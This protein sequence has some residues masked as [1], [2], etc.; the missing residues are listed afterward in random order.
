[1]ASFHDDP[2][3][4]EN[5]G[6]RKMDPLV[7][8][9][10]AAAPAAAHAPAMSADLALA[11]SKR[12]TRRVLELIEAG[13]D[14]NVVFENG[15]TLLMHYTRNGDRDPSMVRA[16]LKRGVNNFDVANPKDGETPIMLTLGNGNRP[17]YYFMDIFKDLLYAGA[18]VTAVDNRGQTLWNHISFCPGEVQT[19]A[20]GLMTRQKKKAA[21]SKPALAKD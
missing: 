14:G 16:L 3:D 17:G 6:R 13:V 4:C 1:M 10:A 20:K 21:A 11:V 9:P 2:R 19:Q 7:M 12:D 18:D 8:L 15:D 5:C